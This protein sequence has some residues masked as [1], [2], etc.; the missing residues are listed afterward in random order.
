MTHD[1]NPID[2]VSLMFEAA[3]SYLGGAK[4]IIDS[5]GISDD[6]GA[7][8]PTLPV[9]TCLMLAI[10]IQLK[11]LLV[12]HSIERPKGYGHDLLS[13]FNALPQSVQVELVEF[14]TSFTEFDEDAFRKLLVD[15]RDTFKTWRYPY[16]KPVLE[17]QPAPLYHVALALS[18]YLKSH[19]QIERSDNGWL[20]KGAT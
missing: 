5:D 7:L 12:A 6:H 4:I 3:R 2:T 18:E 9:T 10:E 8:I 14:Q 20:R 13:L 16:E 15:E 1:N 17:T 19:F 11:A